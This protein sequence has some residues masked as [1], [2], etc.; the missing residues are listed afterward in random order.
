MPDEALKGG[1]VRRWQKVSGRVD[2]RRSTRKV[3][4]EI[5]QARTDTLL[6]GPSDHGDWNHIMSV[7]VAKFG[8]TV[9]VMDR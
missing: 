8:E 5:R 7:E 3:R 6:H 9:I 4:R 2:R 1:S